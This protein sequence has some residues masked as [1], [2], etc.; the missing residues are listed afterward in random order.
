M[1]TNSDEECVTNK[2]I[3]H[4]KKFNQNFQENIVKRRDLLEFCPN[5]LTIF[6]F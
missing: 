1:E 6:E 2:I 5:F 4:T 3:M